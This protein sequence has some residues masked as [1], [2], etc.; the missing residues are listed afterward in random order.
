MASNSHQLCLHIFTLFLY[1][2]YLEEEKE[3]ALEKNPLIWCHKER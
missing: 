3:M 2:C 1:E